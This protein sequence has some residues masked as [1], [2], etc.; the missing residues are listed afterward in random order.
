MKQMKVRDL[1]LGDGIPKIC[2]P[3]IARTYSELVSSLK[4]LKTGSFDLVEFRADYYSEEEAPAL[5]AVRDA[6]GNRP[7]I[8]TIRTEE[9]GGEAG[10]SD[11]Q[12]A[13]RILASVPWAD[14]V[15][16]Q[17]GRVLSRE[18]KEGLHSDLVSRVHASGAKVVLSWH[19]FEKTPGEEVLVEKMCRMAAEG[20]DI[21]KIAVMPRGRRDVC[22]LLN[23]SVEML[24]KDLC[25]FITISM[26]DLGKMTR[27]AGAF[28]G[29]CV[30][31]GAA[32][33]TSAPGQINADTLR[34][35]L[36]LLQP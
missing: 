16:I 34:K 21:A 32:C 30:T 35:I 4:T 2:V 29:S 5:F 33:G 12:Y 25:P 20:C 9:E 27:M 6:A 36:S 24:E 28:S 1:T 3:V 14:L 10:I 19:D 17:L 15:D 18:G 22:A 13:E 11:D 26:G 8:Y 31:F 23:A 7:V